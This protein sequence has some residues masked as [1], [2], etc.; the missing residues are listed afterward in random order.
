[1]PEKSRSDANRYVW[2][3]SVPDPGQLVKIRR[4]QWVVG[5][6]HLKYWIRCAGAAFPDGTLKLGLSNAAD[7]SGT[8][9]YVDISGLAA[10]TDWS[11]WRMAIDRLVAARNAGQLALVT[12]DCLLV[13]LMACPIGLRYK[14]R[15][16]QDAMKA[17]RR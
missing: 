6:T 12:M 9:Y 2:S 17:K 16:E 11:A 10:D 1:M 7:T 3:R 13:G 8:E 14:S 4:R 15:I 5:Y